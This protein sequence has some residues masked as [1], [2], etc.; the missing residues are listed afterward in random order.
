MLKLLATAKQQHLPKKMVKFDKR[1]HKK[2][3][4]KTK[5]SLKSVNTKDK[6]Y[7]KLIKTDIDEDPQYVTFK[8]ELYKKTLG[9]S[10][11]EA[12]GYIKYEHT[13]CIK[14]M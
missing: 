8:N 3:N 11:N 7:E 6:L 10:T 14:M 1:K 5:W 12:S 9:R 2:A 13:H 4:W